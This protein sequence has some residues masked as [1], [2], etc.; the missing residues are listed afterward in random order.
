MGS[1]RQKAYRLGLWAEVLAAFYLMLRGYRILSRRYK[2]RQG[3]IDLVARKGK[4]VVFIE[5]K[6][7]SDLST[8]LEAVT[9]RTQKRVMAAA[10]G[11]IAKNMKYQAY[12]LRFDVI[13]IC[14][15]F[16]VKH[17]DNAWFS[18]T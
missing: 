2:T 9:P 12:D 6:G 11:F 16:S 18:T 3:E 1:F 13:A 14:P 10:N 15:P 7:R 5:V 4:T 8:A 17:L